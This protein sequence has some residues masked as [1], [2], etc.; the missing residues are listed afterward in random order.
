M[1]LPM[2]APLVAFHKRAVWSEE[3]VTTLVPSGL[4][5]VAEMAAP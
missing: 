5:C 1:G 4:K 3:V 2:G